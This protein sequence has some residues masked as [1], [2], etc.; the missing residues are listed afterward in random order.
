MRHKLF[1]F[2]VDRAYESKLD[3]R[4]A[5]ANAFWGKWKEKMG[6]RLKGVLPKAI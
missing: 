5:F 6:S 2:Q 3:E 4:C 1:L